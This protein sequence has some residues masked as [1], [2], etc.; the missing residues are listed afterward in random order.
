[1]GCLSLS[2]GFEGPARRFRDKLVVWQTHGLGHGWIELEE[3]IEHPAPEAG[4]P[5]FDDFFGT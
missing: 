5:L 4:F 2:S 1:M 3:P